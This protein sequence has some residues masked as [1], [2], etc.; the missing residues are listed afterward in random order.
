MQKIRY[1]LDPHNRLVVNSDK[2]S[3]LT[4]FRK[5]LDGSF[6]TDKNN[7]LTYHIKSPLSKEENIPHQLKLR[8]RWSLTKNYD[9]RLTLDKEGR[10]TFG[11]QITLQ[12][13]IL[14]VNSNSLLFA[15]TTKTK[16]NIQSSYILNLGGSWRAD[17]HNRLSFHIRKEEGRHDILTFKGA[18]E[19]NKNHQIIYDYKKS[20]LIRK[21]SKAHTLIFKGYWD[22][23]SS[24]R[25]SYILNKDTNSVFQFRTSAGIFKGNYIKYELGIGLN[26]RRMPKKQAVTLFGRWKIKKDVGLMFEVEY[27]NKKINEIIFGAEAKLTD[28]DTILF[29]LKED[30]TNRDIGIK[31]ELS[32]DI[33]KGD[34]QAFMRLLRERGES[35]IYIGTA[36]RW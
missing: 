6:K 14:E 24:T 13:E 11:D 9:L 23:K 33:L 28:K 34:G 29:K 15:I 19:V 31:V 4:K 3:E 10:E 7:N 16:D 36:W 8:G 17:K 18:W 2:K 22:I 30:I 1:E 35:A 32:H 26:N 27:E 12:G 20:D 5:V 21:S 25:I